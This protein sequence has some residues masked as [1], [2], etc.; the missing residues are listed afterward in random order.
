M[1]LSKRSLSLGGDVDPHVAKSMVYDSK[2]G[3]VDQALAGLGINFQ[4]I[5]W[6]A[7]K[8]QKLHRTQN[9]FT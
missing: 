2:S 7:Q 9:A 6:S 4:R 3:A 8:I 5:G 1:D